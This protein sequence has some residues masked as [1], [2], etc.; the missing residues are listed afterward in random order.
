MNERKIFERKI[1]STYTTAK[2]REAFSEHLHFFVSHLQ[3]FN[4]RSY[5][6]NPD[7][8][9]YKSRVTEQ[10]SDTDVRCYCKQQHRVVV[11]DGGYSILR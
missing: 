10:H 9:N 2:I 6:K 11:V 1:R 8:Q 3:S 4:S 5:V 7:D